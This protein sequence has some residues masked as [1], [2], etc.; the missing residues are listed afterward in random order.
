MNAHATVQ[1]A[2]PVW[3][4]VTGVHLRRPT[5]CAE[6]DVQALAQHTL[7]GLTMVA[8]TLTGEDRLNPGQL[9][10][11]PASG[12]ET[13][14]MF[15]LGAVDSITDGE[16]PTHSRV[17][18]MTANELVALITGDLLVHTWDL[19]KAIGVDYQ[20]PLDAAQATLESS[21]AS[22]GPDAE[23]RRDKP[24]DVAKDVLANA[25]PTD[26]LAAWFGRN[27]NWTGGE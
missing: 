11:S 1:A 25:T 22:M 3:D 20:P 2:R 14:S 15:F 19:A 17:G 5:P 10:T 6:W 27:P 23:S 8:R 16:A 4:A 18:R 13:A 24:F 12:F 21:Q 7:G 9:A 26:K